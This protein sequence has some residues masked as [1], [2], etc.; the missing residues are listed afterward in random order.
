MLWCVSL[1]YIYINTFSVHQQWMWQFK[2]K[3]SSLSKNSVSNVIIHIKHVIFAVCNMPI[4]HIIKS[5]FG[6]VDPKTTS[7]E[8]YI[9][10]KVNA[11][12]CTCTIQF[13]FPPQ[14]I[15]TH[16]DMFARLYL[17][18]S[19][20]INGWYTFATSMFLLF[21]WSASNYG[22][23]SVVSLSLSFPLSVCCCALLVLV[24]ARLSVSLT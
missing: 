1:L 17:S 2:G 11:T 15:E 16:R 21:D 4:I 22:I 10:T 8:R 24:F 23:T 18:F 19:V 3:K 14:T 7:T 9:L 13:V 12:H 6:N 5:I 20:Y